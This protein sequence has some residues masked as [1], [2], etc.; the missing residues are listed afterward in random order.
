MLKLSRNLIICRGKIREFHN[1][2][3]D[4]SADQ[5]K[6]VYPYGITSLADKK[7]FLQKGDIVKF[8]VAIVKETGKTR[9]TNIAAVRKFQRSKVDSIKGQVRNLKQCNICQYKFSDNMLWL[10]CDN[11]K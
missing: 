4:W 3:F 10:V 6:E 5:V 1:E 7:D 11:K 9:A 8:Q 2:Y